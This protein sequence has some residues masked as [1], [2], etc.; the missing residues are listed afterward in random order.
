MFGGQATG[1]KPRGIRPVGRFIL[2]PL[3]DALLLLCW[4][5]GLLRNDVSW[6][7]HR[8]AV[9]S[10]TALLPLPARPAARW[11]SAQ[12]AVMLLAIRLFR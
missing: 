10:G 6:R 2:L 1:R 4:I 8:L 3:K 5:I 9:R 11:R 12:T 7:G